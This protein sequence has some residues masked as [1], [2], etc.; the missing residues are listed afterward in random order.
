MQGRTGNKGP[1][2]NQSLAI[3]RGMPSEEDIDMTITF[4]EQD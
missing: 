2:T 1:E 3:I 4:V